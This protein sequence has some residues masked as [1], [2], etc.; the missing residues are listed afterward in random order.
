[1]KLTRKMKDSKFYDIMPLQLINLGMTLS[2]VCFYIGYFYRTKNNSLHRAINM[3]GVVFNLS[4][5]IYLLAHKYML[6]GIEAAGIFPTVPVLYI[7]IHRFFAAISLI[8]MLMMAATG[9]AKKKD[10]HKKI[11]FIF[12]P[13]YTVVFISGLFIFESR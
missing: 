6:N 4:T 3:T 11:H 1:M 8:L 2:I 7:H 13:L 5:A 12:L 9:I 10:L